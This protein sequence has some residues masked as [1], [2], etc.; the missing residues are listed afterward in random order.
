[1]PPKISEERTRKEMIDPQLEKAVKNYIVY[2][3]GKNFCKVWVQASKLNIWVDIAPSDLQD[4]ISLACD[5]T[6]V[7]H[8]GTGDVEIPFDS[9]GQLDAIMAIVEQAYQQAV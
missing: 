9:A 1:M 3:H 7:G 4:P 2:K 5:V 8:W 6:K